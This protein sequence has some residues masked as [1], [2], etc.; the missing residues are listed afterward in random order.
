[1]KTWGRKVEAKSEAGKRDDNSNG[2][3]LATESEINGKGEGYGRELDL[4]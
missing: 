4:E 2:N 3:I 1:M